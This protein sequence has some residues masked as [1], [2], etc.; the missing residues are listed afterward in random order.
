MLVRLSP[1]QNR[2]A[3][4]R[5]V[6]TKRARTIFSFM[7]HTT[8]RCTGMKGALPSCFSKYAVISSIVLQSTHASSQDLSFTPH[9]RTHIS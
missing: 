5:P 4:L 9:T 3:L 8:A 7:P 6:T 1:T 2:I